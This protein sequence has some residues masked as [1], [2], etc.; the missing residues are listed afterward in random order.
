MPKST[1]QTRPPRGSAAVHTPKSA[2]ELPAILRD[3][4]TPKAIDK[5]RQRL[6]ATA[7]TPPVRSPTR[8]T[9]QKEP[10]HRI[11]TEA[12]IREVFRVAAG[13]DIGPMMIRLAVGM[14][15]D[16]LQGEGNRINAA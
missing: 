2:P 12:E 9:I 8:A 5:E 4:R 10:H 13:R 16:H 11:A 3:V 15:L 7:A 6:A 14:L 1:V